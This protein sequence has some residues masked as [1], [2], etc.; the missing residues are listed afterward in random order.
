MR[1]HRKQNLITRKHILL[2]RKQTFLTAVAT[3]AFG[4]SGTVS[5]IRA[6]ANGP[7][8]TVELIADKDNRFKFPD[9]QKGPLQLKA[10]EIVRFRITSYFGGEKARDG[11]VH[12]FVVKKLR[13]KDRAWSVRLQEG[14]QE[15]TVT[16]PSPG[17]YTIECT[18][19]CGKGHDDM[20][21]QMVVVK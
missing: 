2:T 1:M 17:K 10:G 4:L 11:A 21:M 20:N 16:A 13:E 3:I 12:S 6:E 14:V 19:E 18:V 7:A 5:L 8:R 15:F 9:G